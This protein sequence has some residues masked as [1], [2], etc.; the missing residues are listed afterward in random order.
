MEEGKAQE[1]AHWCL[2][3]PAFLPSPPISGTVMAAGPPSA[4]KVVYSMGSDCTTTGMVFRP[5]NLFGSLT[6]GMV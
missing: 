4:G 6:E 3:D 5:P 1:R 2:P